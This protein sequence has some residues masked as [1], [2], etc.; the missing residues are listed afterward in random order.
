MALAQFRHP[1]A[2]RELHLPQA[3]VAY[4]LVRARRRSIGLVVRA[5]GL[6]VRAPLH[7]TLASIDAALRHKADW[8]VRKLADSQQRQAQQQQARIDWADGALLAYLGAPLQLR[9]DASAPAAGVLQDSPAALLLGLPAHA[10][11]GQLR[12]A[13]RLWLMQRAQ[14]HFT[15]RLDH[16]A[17]LLGVRWARLRLSSAHTRWGVTSSA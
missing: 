15:Q 6:S 14:A 16:F 7:S 5:E 17:P 1:Q 4:L 8:I 3:V 13:V 2:N 9:L 11:A 10:S 12:D